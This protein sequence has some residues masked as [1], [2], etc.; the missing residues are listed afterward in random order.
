MV[1]LAV[2]PSVAAAII[3][4]VCGEV[5]LKAKHCVSDIVKSLA[6]QY[7]AKTFKGL[8]MLHTRGIWSLLKDTEN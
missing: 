4:I 1:L 8:I 3:H 5:K 7:A 2:C 6:C